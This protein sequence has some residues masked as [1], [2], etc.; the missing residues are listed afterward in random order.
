MFYIEEAKTMC[1]EISQFGNFLV[2]RQN[3]N[4]TH[5]I[6]SSL[7]VTLQVQILYCQAHNLFTYKIVILVMMLQNS[8]GSDDNK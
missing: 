1:I 5:L 3:R 4:L 2:F 6:L 7:G 8:G